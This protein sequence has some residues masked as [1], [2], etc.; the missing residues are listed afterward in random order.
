MS[1]KV[2][3][4]KKHF[5]RMKQ[6]KYKEIKSKDEEIKSNHEEIKRR[7]AALAAKSEVAGDGKAESE[8]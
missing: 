3:L 7:K 8:A 2:D 5:R 4:S 6:S 1:K